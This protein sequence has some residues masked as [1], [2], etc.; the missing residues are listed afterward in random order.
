[1]TAMLRRVLDAA[2][3]WLDRLLDTVVL[4]TAAWTVAY[5]ACLLLDLGVRWAFGITVLALGG[6]LAAYAALRR[7]AAK[8]DVDHE[9]VA[10]SSLRGLLRSRPAAATVALAVTASLAMAFDA[11]WPLVWI[12][13]LLAAISGTVTAALWLGHDVDPDDPPREAGEH[14][15][16][17][18]VLVWALAMAAL[19]L[20][21]LS[22]NSDDLFYVSVSQWVAEHGTFPLRDTIFSD[23]AFPIANWPPLASYDGGAGAVGRLFGIPAGTV[24]YVVVPPLASFLAVL[25]MWRLL[26]AWRVPY[27]AVVLSIA[28]VFLLVDGTTSSMTPGNLFATRLWQGKVILLCVLVPWL[29][30]RLVHYFDRPDRRGALWLL[31]GGI[32]SVGLTTTAMFLVPLI[33][34]AGASPLLR[35][36][37][38]QAAIAFAATA[39]YPL[40]A[41]IV[42]TAVG[43]YS[44]D[45]FDS[46]KLF[47]FDPEWIGHKLFSTGLLAIV[48]VGAVLLGSLLVPHRGARLTTGLCALA[49]GVVLIPGVTDLS[50]DLVG[51]GPTLW[52]FS[53]ACTI[54]LLVGVLAVRLAGLLPGRQVWNVG[55]TA[56]LVVALLAAFGEPITAQAQWQEPLHW[57]RREDDLRVTYRLRARLPDGSR[58]L[59]GNSLGVTLAVTTTRLKTVAPRYY[60]VDYLK[61][62]PDFNFTERRTLL[63]YANGKG[64]RLTDSELE[65][66]LEAVPID[67][68]CLD[69]TYEHRIRALQRLG[70]TPMF[71]TPEVSCL[72]R[73]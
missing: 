35:A 29:L 5:H 6:W 47:R 21:T 11:P 56:L 14:R 43:G 39:L 9:E 38:R 52:R 13:W 62:D 64:R 42:T 19:S 66:T 37:R 54:A 25:A 15:T 68:A 40:A 30:A 23:L 51:L 70:M 4:M 32:A 53:W 3:P 27:V 20:W 57:Q 28:L 18:I 7:P 65:A 46:R 69:S 63:N 33:A 36:H 34:L 61:D 24:V 17:V 60:Y 59:V 71:G 67:A 49:L 45:V 50:Y 8:T 1:M 58:V 31:T 2:P 16:V 72:G 12:P 55:G 48:G 26:R 22:P 41:A 44:A 73:P 10:T